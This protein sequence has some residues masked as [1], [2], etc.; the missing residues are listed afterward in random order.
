MYRGVNLIM[1]WNP[2][3]CPCK[4]V[5][6]GNLAYEDWQHKCEEHMAL[7]DQTL[8]DTVATHN[9]VYQL[10]GT[11]TPAEKNQNQ[12]D[13]KTEYDRIKALGPGVTK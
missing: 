6:D 1:E 4:L 12:I 3:T 8:V 2:D 11:P 10:T 5:I 9:K 13:K 7:S